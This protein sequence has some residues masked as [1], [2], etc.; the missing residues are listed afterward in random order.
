[1]ITAAELKNRVVA[2][3]SR[4]GRPDLAED[5]LGQVEAPTLLIVG[6]EDHT[7]LEL[8][9]KAASQMHCRRRYWALAGPPHSEHKDKDDVLDGET[10]VRGNRIL[11]REWGH[12][13]HMADIGVRGIGPTR[14]AAFEEAAKALTAVITDPVLVCPET[15]LEVD[16]YGK[17]DT[18]LLLDWLNA[19]IFEMSTRRMIFGK[20]EV[21]I[22]DRHLHGRAWGEA[23][24]PVRHQPAVEIKGATFTELKVV[25]DAQGLWIAQCVV[26]V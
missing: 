17:E 11:V 9:R 5:V 22:S 10:G 19:L 15:M 14:E 7:V 24:D 16:C 13:E 18:L 26:D 8:N 1:L 21:F 3:V 2:V 25:R 4:G 20:F 12:F 6:G 23:M